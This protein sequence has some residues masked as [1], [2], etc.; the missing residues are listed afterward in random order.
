MGAVLAAMGDRGYGYTYRVLDSQFFGVP[1]RRRRVFVVGCAGGAC[2]PEVLFEPE[3]LPGDSPPSRETGQGVAGTLSPGTHPGGVTGREAESGQLVVGT[4]GGRRGPGPE[5]AARGLLVS[6][7]IT[8]REH[9]GADSDCTSGVVLAHTLRA[10]GHDASEDGTGRG[11]PIVATYQADDYHEGGYE[12]ADTAR[13][14]TT[15]ADRTRAAPI[16][17]AINQRREGRVS[18]VRGSLHEPSGTQVDGVLS[19]HHSGY[20]ASVGEQSATLQASDARLSNQVHGVI[21]HAIPR[22]LT[23]R[24][25]ER[26]QAFPDDW[27]RYD[28][29]GWEIADSPRYRMLGNAVTVSVAEWIGRRIVETETTK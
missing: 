4:L 19:F 11:T 15:S 6:H 25:C 12:E 7:S 9:K 28:S 3:S 2:P 21:D 8:G 29:E 1:Q 16:A 22:R 10:E 27:T 18:E 13:P 26:L 24:E 14:L 17:F 5:E 23:P 20:G